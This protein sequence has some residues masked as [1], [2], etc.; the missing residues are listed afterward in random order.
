[1]LPTTLGILLPAVEGLQLGSWL[2]TI[3]GPC[4]GITLGNPLTL[5]DG[6]LLCVFVGLV[7]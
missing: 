3:L 7:L 6:T 2:G 5:K 1:V 4:E